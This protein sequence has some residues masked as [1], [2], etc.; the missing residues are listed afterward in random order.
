MKFQ[1]QNAKKTM[2]K[3]EFIKRPDCKNVTIFQHKMN[4]KFT[5]I[6]FKKRLMRDVKESIKA[7]RPIA[8]V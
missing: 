8:A 2:K 3:Q 6:E 4:D 7:N 5:V 1:S